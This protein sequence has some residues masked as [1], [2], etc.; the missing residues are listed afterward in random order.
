VSLIVYRQGTEIDYF[1]LGDSIASGHGLMDDESDCRRSESAYPNHVRLELSRRYDNVNYHH[2]A[3]TGATATGPDY[4]ALAKDQ[5]K[6]LSNQIGSVVIAKLNDPSSD[7]PVLV[8]ITIGANDLK[9]ADPKNLEDRLY[10][11]SNTQYQNWLAGKVDE[12]KKA[13]GADLDR[14]LA[15][16]NVAVVVTE[17][18]NPF[19]RESI[20]F[21]FNTF[22]KDH[23][24]F[25]APCYERTEMAARKLNEAFYDLWGERGHTPRLRIAPAYAKFKGH[26]SPGSPYVSSACGSANP[27][28]VLDT[29]IQYKDDE[30]SNSNPL[31]DYPELAKKVAPAPWKGDCFHPNILG[32]EYY[33]QAVNDAA[34][35][36]DR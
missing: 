19:N 1:A 35:Q 15:H 14:L 6:W 11:D 25:V 10:W 18:Y 26:E 30:R 31:K 9:F 13:L 23:C 5:N 27:P 7:N 16:P 28:D 32:A 12:I 4:K 17:I 33:G 8:S 2:L 20:F 36:M 34:L 29:W 21:K 22:S 3:C 24:F